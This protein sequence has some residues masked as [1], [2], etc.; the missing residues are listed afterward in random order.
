MQYISVKRSD[1]TVLEVSDSYNLE[2]AS[3]DDLRSLLTS[4]IP[5]REIDD[6]PLEITDG[7]CT[8]FFDADKL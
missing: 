8:R 5:I 3:Q 1:I 7:N 6:V 4:S 2:D